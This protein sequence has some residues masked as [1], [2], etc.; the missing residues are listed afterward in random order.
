MA[1]GLVQGR[2]GTWRGHPNYL[3]TTRGGQSYLVSV[4]AANPGAPI[5]A[6]ATAPLLA[7]V[8]GAFGLAAG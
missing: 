7:A 1:A 3:A 2:L 6:A 4:M 5:P 8:K